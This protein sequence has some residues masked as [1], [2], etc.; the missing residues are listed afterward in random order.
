GRN[1]LSTD[2]IPQLGIHIVQLPPNAN[3]QAEAHAF[4]GLNDVEFAE[5]DQILAP[6]SITPFDTYYAYEW[7]LPKLMLPDAWSI[8]TG[9]STIIAFVDTG[10]DGTHVDLSAKMVAGWNTVDNTA[11]TS[12]IVGHGT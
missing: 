7:P 6:S 1:A 11:L 2:V 3:E 4:K 12:D 5:V 10:V 8:T 9:T